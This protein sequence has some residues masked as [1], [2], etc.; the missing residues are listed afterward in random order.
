MA[1]IPEEETC[2]TRVALYVSC[3]NLL[4]KDITSKSDPL[5]VFN[6]HNGCYWVEHQR[7][8]WIKNTSCPEFVTP[9]VIDFYFEKIQK[10]KLSVYDIDN[11]TE[12]LSDDDFLG[13]IETTLAK[14]VAA[15]SYTDHLKIPPHKVSQGTIH[16]R[17]EEMSDSRTNK[18]LALKFKGQNLD[19]MDIFSKS[20]PYLEIC[21]LTSDSTYLKIHRTEIIKNT[22][23]PD[24]NLFLIS[25]DTLCN[26]DYERSLQINCYDYDN[27]GSHDFIGS[28]ATTLADMLGAKDN[29]I[30]YDCINP[31]KQAKKN[32]YKN[33]GRIILQSVNII[34]DH[35][36]LDYIIGGCQINLAIGIDFTIS[37]KVATNPKSLHYTGPNGKNQYLDAI[38]AVGNVCAD[39][40]FDKLIPVFGFGAEIPPKNKVSHAF[41]INFNATNPNVEGIEGV[42]A[43]YK[44]CI[45]K[46]Q[47]YFPTNFAPI[48]NH[49]ASFAANAAEDGTAS[50]YFILLLLTDGAITDTDKTKQ[51]LVKA[52]KLPMSVIIV[53]IGDADFTAMKD[54]DCDHGVL[55]SSSGECAL[56]D[57]VQFVSYK[58]FLQA[59]S[60]VLAQHVLSEIPRQLRQ[61][62]LLSDMEPMVR[63]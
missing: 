38:K 40:D 44:N 41:P 25:V 42:I 17:A 23:N 8:E 59:P 18:I 46:I 5:V 10:V 58:K 7:T 20:D 37:N 45:S 29:P 13:E 2:L 33:S 57:I 21:K 55:K 34:N 19:K 63:H 39:Y 16:I 61:H 62:Y 6:V 14:I 60:D 30:S 15:E 9:I 22:L 26:G 36:F 50:N 49:I 53:G 54:L 48:I 43:A 1:T 32:T 35:S 12:T 24:W 56:R 11:D 31:K 52:S 47:F 51:A 3:K 28:F 27:N 4:K